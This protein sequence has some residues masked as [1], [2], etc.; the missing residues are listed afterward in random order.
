M[1]KNCGKNFQVSSGARIY[2]LGKLDVGD[3]VFIATNVVI[4]TGGVII[5]ESNVMI[6][7]GSVLVAGDHTIK[8]DSYRY[9]ER[10]EADINVGRGSWIAANCTVVKGAIVPPS[11]VV[12]ANSIYK[13]VH[14]ISGVYAGVPAVLVKKN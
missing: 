2:G 11:S 14:S 1:M 12:A 5:L 10:Q 4:N 9:G 6:G 7:I 3:N 8:N 13:G